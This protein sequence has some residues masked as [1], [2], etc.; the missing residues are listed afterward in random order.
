MGLVS[1][2]PQ[3]KDENSPYGFLI[4]Q[5]LSAI[6]QIAVVAIKQRKFTWRIK[7]TV[8]E[9]LLRGEAE[10]K[11]KTILFAKKYRNACQFDNWTSKC[12]IP[13]VPSFV[14]SFWSPL[15][16]MFHHHSVSTLEKSLYRANVLYVIVV[17]KQ[18]LNCE[19]AYLG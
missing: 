3:K 7:K 13:I 9:L 15:G 1:K 18:F 19:L 6:L 4:Y 5:R 10:S 14:T 2:E 8:Q 17:N 11:I 12:W 16:F